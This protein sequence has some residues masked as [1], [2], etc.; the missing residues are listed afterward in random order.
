MYIHHQWSFSPLWRTVGL[1]QNCSKIQSS[2]IEVKRKIS[3]KHCWQQLYLYL[4]IYSCYLQNWWFSSWEG[5]VIN[6]GCQSNPS[7][8]SAPPKLLSCMS[9]AWSTVE[10]KPAL[11]R[12]HIKLHF[13]QFLQDTVTVKCEVVP[14]RVVVLEKS[15]STPSGLSVLSTAAHSRN[16]L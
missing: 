14:D 16:H 8:T 11:Y 1:Q 15:S 6:M 7:Y 12:K 13:I 5:G 9:S 3:N 2:Y 10:R 4:M